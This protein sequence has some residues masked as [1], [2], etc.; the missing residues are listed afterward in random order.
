MI[1]EPSNVKLLQY[2]VCSVVGVFTKIFCTWLAYDG[3]EAQ[4]IP[5]TVKKSI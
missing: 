2:F 4:K 3:Q 1:H 5:G